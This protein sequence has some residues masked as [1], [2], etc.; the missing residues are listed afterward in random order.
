MDRRTQ[1]ELDGHR[2]LVADHCELVDL[3]AQL[4]E[5]IAKMEDL[6][7]RKRL[8]CAVES[9]GLAGGGDWVRTLTPTGWTKEY[10]E[11]DVDGADPMEDVGGGYDD[12]G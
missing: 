3:V 11:P 9:T 6:L 12:L 5:R 2:A 4:E 8:R 1:I 7:S 10:R